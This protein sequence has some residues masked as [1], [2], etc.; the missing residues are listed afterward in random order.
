MMN[1]VKGGNGGDPPEL[2]KKEREALKTVVLHTFVVNPLTV[3]P[4]DTVTASWNVTIPTDTPFDMFVELNGKAMPPTG[5]QTF[6]V[7]QQTVFSLA[8][9]ISDDPT[10]ARILRQVTVHLDTSECRSESFPASV[11]T[12]PLKQVFDDVFG[13]AGQF[14]LKDG[15]TSVTAGDA[16]A[17]N[18]DVPLSINVP[19]WFDADMNIAIQLTITGASQVFVAAPVVNPQVSW[20]FLS[21]LLSLACTS[22]IGDGM[23]QI[24]KVFLEEIVDQQLRPRVTQM[25]VDQINAFTGS[26]ETAD[27]QHRTYVMTS[28]I[29]NASGLLITACPK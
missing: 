11:V 5:S 29:F 25:L 18:I 7:N 1:L 10:V 23:T 27:P 4:F 6:A 14:T 28:L 8:A 22:F 2:V 19:D 9:A 12:A 3:K 17:V 26:L 13:G 16:G 24:S 15:G 20:S 21:N